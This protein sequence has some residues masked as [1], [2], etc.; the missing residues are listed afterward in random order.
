[1]SR[2]PASSSAAGGSSLP[3][4]CK[5]P[6]SFCGVRH[7]I[8]PRT[9]SRWHRLRAESPSSPASSSPMKWHERARPR[10]HDRHVAPSN[11]RTN[12]APSEG[13]FALWITCTVQIHDRTARSY[14]PPAHDFKPTSSAAGISSLW[15]WP[16]PRIP[17]PDPYCGS[18]A[19]AAQGYLA[20]W[21]AWAG[22]RTDALRTRPPPWSA[23][24]VSLLPPTRD[25]A[26]VSLSRLHPGR[27]E[28]IQEKQSEAIISNHKQSAT[29]PQRARDDPTRAGSAG[30]TLV[31]RVPGAGPT[32]TSGAG[33]WFEA[34]ACMTCAQR[35]LARMLR[36]VL[37]DQAGRRAP[38][39]MPARVTRARPFVASRRRH[40]A[41]VCGAV[42][43]A[44]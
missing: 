18:A 2:L 29:S 25:G 8:N 27:R 9:K 22:G 4:F 34:H 5:L 43:G 30:P 35:L 12:V 28:T 15:R 7:W 16:T 26:R 42:C 10:G 32:V 36:D 14:V 44:V 24:D 3:S 21:G 23:A 33:S 40:G 37:I 11:E 13:S 6:H 17:R 38:T 39:G 41:A 19:A 1:M 31:A 20:P